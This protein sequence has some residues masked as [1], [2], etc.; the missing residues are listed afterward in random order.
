VTTDTR[1]RAKARLDRQI[2][3]CTKCKGLNIENET[4]AAPGFGSLY[5]PVAIVGE[6]LCRKCMEEREPFV[7]GSGLILDKAFARAGYDK[8]DLFITNSIHCHPPGDRDPKPEESKNCAGFLRKELREIVQPRLVIGVGRYAKAAVRSL[9]EA[10][11]RELN[12]PFRVPRPRLLGGT[13]G[14]VCPGSDR[15]HPRGHRHEDADAVSD[16]RRRVAR[17]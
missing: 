5:S 4:E 15:S 6:A 3:R 1:Q 8:A 9:Y 7:G 2:K 12:W 10:E 16:R 11:A 17:H 13:S 14:S